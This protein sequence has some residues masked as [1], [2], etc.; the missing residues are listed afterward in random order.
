MRHTTNMLKSSEG[1]CEYIMQHPVIMRL[2]HNTDIGMHLMDSYGF[3]ALDALLLID[4][5]MMADD[6]G[7]SRVAHGSTTDMSANS[8]RIL[9]TLCCGVRRSSN[10]RATYTYTRGTHGGNIGA[11]RTSRAL[12]MVRYV[13]DSEHKQWF[14]V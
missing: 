2:P 14:V 10:A 8:Q 4:A 6:F 9:T 7:T 5:W 3:D 13:G 12:L 11:M 1:V